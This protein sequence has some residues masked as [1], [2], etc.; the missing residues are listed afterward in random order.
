[1]GDWLQAGLIGLV[2]GALSGAFG[3]G[4]GIVTTPAIRLVMGAPALIAVGTPLPVIIPGA[5]TGALSYHRA[6]LIDSRAGFTIALAGAPLTVLGAWLATRMGGGVVLVATA[7]LIVWAATDM[8]LQVRTEQPRSTREPARVIDQVVAPGEPQGRSGDGSP[9]EPP[10]EGPVRAPL[11]ALAGIGVLAGLYSGFLGLGGGFVIV[12]VLTRWLR[13]PIKLAIGTSLVTVA[14]LAVPGTITHS[15]LGNIDWRIAA[16]LA[17]G[18]VPGALLGSKLSMRAA[19]R[20]VRVA[21]SVLLIAVGLWLGL[22]ELGVTGT[23]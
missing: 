23:R 17:V 16:G 11:W 22:S 5:V 6:G 13:F 14:V 12:P 15:A 21:F 19:D 20:S 7:A 1:M 2:S 4:G 18:V 9:T 3:I 10:A 8:L